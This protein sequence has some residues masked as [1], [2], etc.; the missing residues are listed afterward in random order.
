MW[1]LVDAAR[2]CS[3]APSRLLL[4]EGARDEAS[5]LGPERFP[6]PLRPLSALA[7]LAA[8]DLGRR[9]PFEREG[10]PA[11]IAAMLRHRLTGRLPRL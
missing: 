11:R 8:R 1:A 3:D 7:A 4:L 9:Q 5:D 2:H 6:L 10:A